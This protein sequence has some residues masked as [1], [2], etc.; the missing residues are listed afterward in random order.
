MSSRGPDI[1]T[2]LLAASALLPGAIHPF[3]Q[4]NGAEH[5]RHISGDRS[6]AFRGHAG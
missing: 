1:L 5:E 3:L 4:L 2:L 6:P